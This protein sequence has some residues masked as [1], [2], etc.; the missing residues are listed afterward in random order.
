MN[1][2]KIIKNI[3]IYS[4]KTIHSKVL[5]KEISLKKGIKRLFDVNAP[6][7]IACCQQVTVTQTQASPKTKN[8]SSGYPTRDQHE[9]GQA[10]AGQN[11]ALSGDQ[12]ETEPQIDEGISP[13]L[14]LNSN[15]LDDTQESS[16]SEYEKYD[17][18]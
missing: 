8:M 14:D 1:K 12:M 13:E 6:P 18:Q 4:G 9:T 3:I 5:K 17:I 16:Q 2:E 10:M 15:F 7:A 11:N